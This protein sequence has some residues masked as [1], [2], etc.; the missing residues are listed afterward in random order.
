MAFKFFKNGSLR[1]EKGQVREDSTIAAYIR[2]ALRFLQIVLGLTVITLYAPYLV[3]A[4]KQGKYQDSKWLY[5]SITGG[6]SMGFAVLLWFL[7]GW[8]FFCLDILIWFQWLVLFGIFAKL[9]VPEN[10]EGN[11]DI[12]KMKNAVWILLINNLLWLATAIWGG[13]KY[14]QVRKQPTPS[15]V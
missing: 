3:R 10:P 6:L 8:L 11:K 5:A 12:Q 9:Y 2:T 1:G 15:V 14:F 7:R 13:I 4:H